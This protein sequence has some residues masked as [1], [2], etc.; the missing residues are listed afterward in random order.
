MHPL[1]G[2]PHVLRENFAAV[3]FE[4]TNNSFEINIE[5]YS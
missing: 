4:K 3:I 2:P 5:G 1:G